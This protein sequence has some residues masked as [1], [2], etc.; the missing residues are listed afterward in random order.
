MHSSADGDAAITAGRSS[1]R[2][3]VGATSAQSRSIA[4]A[5]G[6]GSQFLEQAP[7]QQI[8][9]RAAQA[10][11]AHAVLEEQE[12]V[13]EGGAEEKYYEGPDEYASWLDQS[14]MY[15]AISGLSTV[16]KSR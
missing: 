13:G 4:G 15:Q 11:E 9:S 7:Q 2:R 5:D 10:F 14:V 12:E 16:R 3:I 6:S 1:S 8:D